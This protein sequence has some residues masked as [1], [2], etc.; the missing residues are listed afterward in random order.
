MHI[1]TKPLHT[2]SKN[3]EK[4]E[5]LGRI[6]GDRHSTVDSNIQF[7]IANCTTRQKINEERDLN[8][9]I[10]HNY[11]A[12]RTS[13]KHS[14]STQNI[15]YFPAHMDHSPGK[16]ESDAIKYVSIN[17]KELKQYNVYPRTMMELAFHNKNKNKIQTI[18]G[19]DKHRPKQPTGQ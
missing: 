3:G 8:N 4:Y 1:K 18:C 11:K 15:D 17:L 12:G 6:E 2:W 5:I 9:A 16:T 19:N 7:S 13:V 14:P 10:N